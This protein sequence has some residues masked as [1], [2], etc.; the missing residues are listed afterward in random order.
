MALQTM[1]PDVSVLGLGIT[2]IKTKM[3]LPRPTLHL[4]MPIIC[5]K[6]ES[7]FSFEGDNM[8]NSPGDPLATARDI[9][10]LAL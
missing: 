3:P 8:N 1:M 6:I 9:Y 7:A 4:Q 10:T 5:I 2:K